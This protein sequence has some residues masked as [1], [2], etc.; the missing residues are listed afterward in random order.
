M[1]DADLNLS[2]RALLGAAFAA[3]VLSRHPGLV[4][5]STSSVGPAAAETKW[6]RALAAY[7][8]AE[9]ELKAYERLTSGA[10]WEEQ[11]AIE[12]THGDMSDVMYDS[13]RRLL[14]AAAPDVRALALKLD[15]VVAHDVGTLRG[16]E[17]CLAALRRDAR[18]L[19]RA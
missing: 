6:G 17:L 2:R 8:T 5:G 18:R 19:S 9:A 11:A 10:P 14:R 3:P 1:A 12:D 16:G 7:R 4:P 15:L 13:L